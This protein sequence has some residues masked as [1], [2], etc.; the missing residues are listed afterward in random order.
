MGQAR[1]ATK[2]A[3]VPDACWCAQTGTGDGGPDRGPL[4]TDPAATQ[5]H[6]M[7]G[8]RR[9]YVHHCYAGNAPRKTRVDGY[10]QKQRTDDTTPTVVS[11][12]A[13][14]AARLQERM[15]A[16]PAGPKHRTSVKDSRECDGQQNATM[17]PHTVGGGSS[18]ARHTR[19]WHTQV[20]RDR[21]N[22]SSRTAQCRGS[23]WPTLNSG[24]APLPYAPRTDLLQTCLLRKLCP[25]Q[26]PSV[27]IGMPP[28]RQQQAAW[29]DGQGWVPLRTS[30][31]R[32]Q[33]AERVLQRSC[34]RWWPESAHPACMNWP[35]HTSD[36]NAILLKEVDGWQVPFQARNCAK[37]GSSRGSTPGSMHV[38][39]S[40]DASQRAPQ[41]H[42]SQLPESAPPTG[43]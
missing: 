28:Q 25:G 27:P 35:P 17:P 29:H 36:K 5:A 34:G 11:G 14:T 26:P 37:V 38:R 16:P 21:H 39:G 15:M 20:T 8:R 12:R 24:H 22:T 23:A 19:S 31:A 3:K 4:P 43:C 18:Q 1:A 13:P 41:Q 40:K 32:S 7:A 2:T 30:G 6:A 33:G 10:M 9:G 42:T